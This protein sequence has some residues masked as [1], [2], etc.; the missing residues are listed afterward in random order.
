MGLAASGKT[1]FSFS[2]AVGFF[3]SVVNMILITC[4]NK[5]SD[6]LSGNSM[7]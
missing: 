1:D 7:W 3:N 2:T 5:I 6:K 4:V